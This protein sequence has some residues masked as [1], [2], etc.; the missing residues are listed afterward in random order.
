MHKPKPEEIKT[1]R[2]ASGLT[3]TACAALIGKTCRAWQYYEV[4]ARK[5][6]PALW[7]L[8]KIKLAEAKKEK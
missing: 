1:A 3:Q 7:E 6:D 8:W 4:G 5:M 2:I